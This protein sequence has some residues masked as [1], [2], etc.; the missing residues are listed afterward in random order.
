MTANITSNTSTNVT[1]STPS[2]GTTPVG[3]EYVIS[4]TNTN[5]TGA[6]T[7]TTLT[8]NSFT[9][10]TPDTTYY[11]FVRS[12]CG[13]SDYSNWAT[14]S[15]FTGYCTYNTTSSSYWIDDFYTTGGNLNIS[16]LNSGYSTNGYGDFTSQFIN[17]SASLSF[18]FNLTLNSGTHGV[19]IWIDWNQDL[20]FD[21]TGE[22]VYASG[23]FATTTS[24][25]INIPAPT[26]T[27]NYRMR[28]TANYSSTDPSRCCILYSSAAADQRPS[29]DRG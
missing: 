4:T 6:G 20:D 13:G 11:V 27:G 5:P 10:L 25:T 18:D 16:N 2:S 9:G 14:T 3:Y 15:F 12:N 22:K 29:V 23:S 26:P 21:D 17:Q 19:N 28:V 1:W 24:G 8:S 7:A